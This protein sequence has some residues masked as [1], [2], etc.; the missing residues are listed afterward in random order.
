MASTGIDR[1]TG[2]VLRDFDHVRQSLEVIFTTVIG[3]RVMRRGFGYLGLGL[4][5]RKFTPSTVL[6]FCAAM[7]MAV[8]LWEPRY[9]V[10]RISF[11]RPQNNVDDA[12]KGQVSIV[13]E[14]FY[15]PRGHL[16]DFTAEEAR[17][18]TLGSTIAMGAA[19]G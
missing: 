6:K 17:T 8:D 14:G 9:R 7:I 2:K 13:I 16:G 19:N 11:P 15:R 3:A 5:G 4:L 12:R 1:R 18:V 10:S